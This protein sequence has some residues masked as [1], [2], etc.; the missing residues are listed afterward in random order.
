MML[1]ANITVGKRILRSFPSLCVLRRHPAPSAENFTAFIQKAKSKNVDIEIET[2]KRLSDSLDTATDADVNTLLRIL[3]TR[4]MSPAKYFVAGE[5]K[6][7]DWHHYGLASPIYLHFTSPIRRYADVLVHRLLAA[8]IGYGSLPGRFTA[9]LMNEQCDIMNRRHRAAQLAGRASISLHTK[10][11]FLNNSTVCDA[12]VVDID[13]VK[14]TLT[15]LILKYGIEGKISLENEFINNEKEAMNTFLE[16]HNEGVAA[17]DDE[18]EEGDKAGGWQKGEGN[19]EV[20]TSFTDTGGRTIS[21]FDKIQVRISVTVD[22]KTTERTLLIE[23]VVEGEGEE[24]EAV[25]SK[26]K[27]AGAGCSSSS[28]G[29]KKRSKK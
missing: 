8:S 10:Q 14:K 19:V 12:H 26:R 4:C 13:K 29:R 11:F 24:D 7:R 25:G 17:G 3:V 22:E 20:C 23:R 27:K 18:E 16:W 9:Q 5:E 28:G 15:V 21:V 2:S 6:I 1:F